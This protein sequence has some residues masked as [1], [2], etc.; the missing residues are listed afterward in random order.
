MKSETLNGNG[1]SEQLAA[2]EKRESQIRLKMAAL[3]EQGRKR[4]KQNEEKEDAM[5]GAAVRK[6]A[7]LS[8]EFK[9]AVAVALVNITDEKQRAFLRSRGWEV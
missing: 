3:R 4:E 6:A 8:P 1:L 2:L 7:A 5:I 9:L